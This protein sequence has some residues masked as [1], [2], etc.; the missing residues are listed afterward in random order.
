MDNLVVDKIIEGGVGLIHLEL[1]KDFC[2]SKH[3]YL[4]SVR[5]TGVKVTVIHTLE[6][7]SMEYGGRIDLAKSYYDG[8]SKSLKK[9]LH[10]T[11]LISGMQQ[12]NDFFFLGTK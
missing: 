5:V 1:A 12:C 4:A 7:L 11:N 9:N 3:A 2:N 6:Y 8:L 10:V